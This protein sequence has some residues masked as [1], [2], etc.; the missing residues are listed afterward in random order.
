[1]G[2]GRCTDQLE[3]GLHGFAGIVVDHGADALD[4]STAGET[5]LRWVLAVVGLF[6][7]KAATASFLA[8]GAEGEIDMR[9]R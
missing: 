9:S 4:T 5:S 3:V 1:M 2:Q 6:V 8:R 7:D